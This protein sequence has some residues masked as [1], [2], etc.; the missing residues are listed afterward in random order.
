[1]PILERSIRCEDGRERPLVYM[2]HGASTHAPRPVLEAVMQLMTRHYANVHRGNHTLSQEASDLWDEAILQIAGFVGA[3]PAKQ[4]PIIVGNTTQANDL[5]AHL[6]ENVPGRVLTTLMEHHS[7]DLPYRARGRVLHAGVD[8]EGRIDLEDVEAKLEQGGVKL[9][10]VSGASNVTGYMPPIHKMARM[11]H[12]HGARILVDGAQLLAHAPIDVKP[13][14]HKEHIDFLSGA[15]HKAYAPFGAGFLLAPRDIADQAA[16]Y[17][18]GGGTVKWVTAESALFADSPDRHQGGTPNITGTIALAAALRYLERIGMESVR[19]HEQE[20]VR[21]GLKRFAELH[22]EHGVELLG[23]HKPKEWKDRLGV[24]AFL[25]PEYRHAGV[26]VRLDRHYAIATR[27]GC[28]CAHPLLHRLLRLGDTSQYTKAIAA[29]QHVELPGATRATLG[30]Y[31]TDHEVDVLCDAIGAIAQ[32]KH[33]GPLRKA[34][35]V[36][37]PGQESS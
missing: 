6:M 15:G 2:D 33:D 5:A 20:L 34:R 25:V 4:V 12:A 24:F 21:Q 35:V 13:V 22:D 7:N 18:P 10:A 23:P 3:D 27:N 36:P 37:R 28:F 26:S 11:A 14:G 9:L 31:N 17:T 8:E 19:R 32:G 16:P 1:F 30:L 29:G